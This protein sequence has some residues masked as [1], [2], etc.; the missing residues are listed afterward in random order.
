MGDY[1]QLKVWQKAQAVAIECHKATQK[2]RGNQHAA[3]RSQITRAAFS[4]PANLVEGNG[5]QSRREYLRF[6]RIALNSNNELDYHI[7]TARELGLIPE[8]KANTLVANNTEV[9]KML[10]GLTR[11]LTSAPDRPPP[12][13][14]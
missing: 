11:F 14:P 6:V 5:L 13:A 7:N 10:H 8:S 12:P 3:L 1:K 4:V 2:I 9:R